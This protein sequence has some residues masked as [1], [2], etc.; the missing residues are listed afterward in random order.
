[1][2]GGSNHPRRPT[3]PPDGT[4][5][6]RLRRWVRTRLFEAGIRPPTVAAWN[7]L[8]DAELERMSSESSEEPE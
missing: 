2:T 3:E 7:V 6:E 8:I 1:M 4:K 5:P